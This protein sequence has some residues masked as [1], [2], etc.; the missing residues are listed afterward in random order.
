[1]GNGWS[2]PRP[3]RFAPGV[4]PGTH[5]TGG[6]VSPKTGLDWCGKYRPHWDS[7]PERPASS[8]SLYRIHYTGPHNKEYMIRWLNDCHAGIHFSP[9]WHNSPTGP[10]PLHYRGFTITFRHTTLGRLL[11]GQVMEPTQRPLPDNTQRSQEAN[12]HVLGGVR[13]HNASKR[14]VAD[15]RLRP[16]GH[17]NRPG[18]HYVG[19][20]G[21]LW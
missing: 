3:G 15:P 18:I 11:S 17:W 5:C 8:Q 14:A 2:A 6:W 10:V 19:I 12:I 1:M 13:T 16:R 21:W 7:I 4:W 9:T 20:N